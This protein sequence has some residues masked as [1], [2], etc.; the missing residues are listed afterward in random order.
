MEPEPASHEARLASLEN[1][2]RELGEAEASRNLPFVEGTPMLPPVG[3][4][5]D[6]VDEHRL[7]SNPYYRGPDLMDRVTRDSMPIPDLVNREGYCDNHFDYWLFGLGDYLKVK[8][9]TDAAGIDLDHARVFDFGGSTGRVFRHFHT[10]HPLAE[11]WSSDFNAGNVRWNLKHLPASIR[12]FLNTIHPHLPIAD[13]SFDVVTAFS[14]FTHIDQL[15]LAWLLEL[16]RITK[17]SGVLYVTWDNLPNN[18]HLL[19]GLKQSAGFIDTL[20][21]AAM[22]EE[23]LAFSWTADNHYN[24]N[25]FHSEAYIRRVWGRFFTI[26]SFKPRHHW[27]QAQ[28]AIQPKRS[29]E[30]P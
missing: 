9:Q 24:C 15:E 13:A 18:A 19:N 6:F 28:V 10:H 25:V 1:Q 7:R 11:V 5:A 14:V 27:E 29:A 26:L 2:R 3:R 8:E 23:R 21:G 30:G 16:R 12:V 22:P 17:P 20:L 4:V